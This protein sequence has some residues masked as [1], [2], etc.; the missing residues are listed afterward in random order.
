MRQVRR[1]S[2]KTL[3]LRNFYPLLSM[4]FIAVVAAAAEPANSPTLRAAPRN[5]E[6]DA[7]TYERCMKLAKQEPARRRAWRRPGTS[8]EGHIRPITAPPSR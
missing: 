3:K 7:A 2:L 4:F 5:A 8:G 6:T 1:N